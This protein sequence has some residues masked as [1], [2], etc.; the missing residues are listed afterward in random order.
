MQPAPGEPETVLR[1]VDQYDGGP[2]MTLLEHLVELRNRVIVAGA[3]LVIGMLISGFFW[4]TILDW[5]VAPGKDADPEFR[6]FAFSPVDRILL[7][8]KISIYGG[9]IIA[10]PVILYELLAFIVPG[11]TPREKKML[12][13]GMLGVV[14]FLLAGMAF[15]YFIIIPAS[16]DFLLNIGDDTFANQTGAK[17]Y[18]DFVTRLIFWVG[19]AFELPM[20]L[21]LMSRL[22]LL[23][24]KQMISFWRYS[25]VII[26]VISA[27][28]TPT[29]DML[30][31]S[32][33][34]GPLLFLYV[35]G[36][37][38]AW[39]VKPRPKVPAA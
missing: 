35:F 8:F 27:I 28:V 29:P 17:E 34:M 37:G 14:A 22:G 30:T 38:L 15:S 31:M 4:E 1:P 36:I 7:V 18:I 12:L 26:A 3:A 16:L 19:L 5:L 23:K 6:L 20:V 2:E 25:V 24:P 13:P 39:V 33:V 10:S 11:L 9:L 21:A 32:L